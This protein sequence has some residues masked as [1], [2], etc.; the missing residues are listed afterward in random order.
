MKIWHYPLE[1]FQSQASS[2]T[3]T[4]NIYF[5]T[6]NVGKCWVRLQNLLALIKKTLLQLYQIVDNPEP[7]LDEWTILFVH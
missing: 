7:D 1:T 5:E 4:S 3:T 2:G 6:E